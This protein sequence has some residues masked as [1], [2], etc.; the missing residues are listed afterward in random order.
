[1][2]RYKV[3]T[4]HG[5][6]GSVHYVVDTWAP[7]GEQ[8][9]VKESYVVYELSAEVAARLNEQSNRNIRGAIQYLAGY[10]R[11]CFDLHAFA[12]PR[13]IAEHRA[14]LMAQLLGVP[15]VPQ[16]EAGMHALTDAFYRALGVKEGCLAEREADFIVKAKAIFERG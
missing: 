10:T 12:G 13:I 15:R 8:P 11:G 5:E 3:T 6:S 9:A 14:Y 7:E 1:M 2:D 4:Q 16:K